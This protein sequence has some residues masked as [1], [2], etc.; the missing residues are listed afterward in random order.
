MQPR[1]HALLFLGLL[2]CSCEFRSRTAAWHF[3][4]GSACKIAYS[5][6]LKAKA[7]GSWGSAPYV[8]AAEAD[9]TARAAVDSATGEIVL[10]L[11][12]DTL[13]YRSSERSPGEDDY[14][15]GRLRKYQARLTLSRTGR[16]LSMEEEPDMPQVEFSP[17]SFGR[18]LAYALPAFPD[19]PIKQGSRWEV[20]QPLLDKF[21]PDS[22]VLKRFALSA[23]RETPEGDLGTCLFELEAYLDEDLGGGGNPSEPSLTGSGQ[24]V[25][26]LTTGRPVSA[27]VRLEGRFATPSPESPAD[28]AHKVG[29]PLHLEE[30]LSLRFSD[31]R[32]F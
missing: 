23:L 6:E 12:V 4:P 25:F 18:L 13:A 28:S 32:A 27:Q 19:E 24:A 16:L 3:A 5:A 17:L 1:F 21:H 29:L 8:S 11:S 9:F 30:E 22:R 2:V 10:S 26:N 15:A 31:D 14:M 7:D 20:T